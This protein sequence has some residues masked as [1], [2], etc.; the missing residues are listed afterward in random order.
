MRRILILLWMLSFIQISAARVEAQADNPTLIEVVKNGR[1]MTMSVRADGQLIATGDDHGQIHLIDPQTEQML[2]EPTPAHAAWVNDLAFSPDGQ[3]LASSGC[4]T[5]LNNIGVCGSGGIIKLWSV[6]VNR[7]TLTELTTLTGQGDTYGI[8]FSPDG[9]FI[10]SAG[11]Y[12]DNS[13]WVWDIQDLNAPTVTHQFAVTY[14]ID[15]AFAPDSQTLAATGCS[16]F[17]ADILTCPEGEVYLFDYVSGLPSEAALAG[18]EGLPFVVTFSPDGQTIAAAGR[19]KILLW[20]W[21]TGEA[22]TTLNAGTG[23][24]YSLAF[25]ES[26]VILLSGDVVGLAQ[27]W[28]LNLFSDDTPLVGS[29]LII[30]SDAVSGVGFIRNEMVVSSSADGHVGIWKSTPG[31]TT[32]DPTSAQMLF[33]HT[34]WVSRALVTPDG[35]TIISGSATDEIIFWDT[36]DGR[37]IA[38]FAAGR[39]GVA[40]LALSSDGA[41]LAVAGA[42]GKIGLWDVAEQIELTVLEGHTSTVWSVAFSPDGTLL[43]SSDNDGLI[44][45]WNIGDFQSVPVDLGM[46]LQGHKGEVWSVAFSPDGQLLASGGSDGLVRL[47]DVETLEPVGEPLTGHLSTVWFVIFSPDG[48]IVASGSQDTSIRLWNIAD[49]SYRLLTG[50]EAAIYALAFSSDGSILASGSGDKTVI[51]WDVAQAQPI[52]DSQTSQSEAV[53]SVAFGLNNQIISAGQSGVVVIELLPDDIP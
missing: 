43:A 5:P 14:P 24:I 48:Q 23:E 40:N 50:H 28:F 12:P 25:S 51:L 27:A 21:R 47:W 19:N 17:D 1:L 46:P 3:M 22:I 35:T 41:V 33:G 18:I 52:G 6:G 16:S 9:D 2:G 20:N 26:G 36:S 32:T 30:H 37:Q 15:V 42:D 7:D 13:V 10:A 45:I 38:N 31:E 4:Q 44:R 53:F 34:G 49:G 39:Q 8:A 29:P 11:G